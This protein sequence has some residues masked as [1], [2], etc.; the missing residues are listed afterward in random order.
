MLE[1]ESAGEV[2]GEDGGSKKVHMPRIYG[3]SGT[4]AERSP[5]HYSTT[6][7]ESQTFHL[8]RWFFSSSIFRTG[9]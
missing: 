5:G 4:S 1:E 3:V 6:P 8:L 2:A 9:S 7:A